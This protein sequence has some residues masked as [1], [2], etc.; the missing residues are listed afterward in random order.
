MLTILIVIRQCLF[1]INDN[2]LLKIYTKIW[3]RVKILMNIEFDSDL[4]YGDNDKYKKIKIKSHGGKVNTHFQ[5]K[6]IRKKNAS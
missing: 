2:K 1:K 6:K 4:I 3:G 5:C